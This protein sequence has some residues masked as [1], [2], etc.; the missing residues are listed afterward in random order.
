M[1]A[2]NANAEKI[3]R[4]MKTETGLASDAEAEKIEKK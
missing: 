3:E 2:S 4:I 1:A